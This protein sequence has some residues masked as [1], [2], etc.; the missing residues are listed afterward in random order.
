MHPKFIH[1]WRNG[2]PRRWLSGTSR[3]AQEKEKEKA[4]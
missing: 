1:R 3:Q 4:E 2:T